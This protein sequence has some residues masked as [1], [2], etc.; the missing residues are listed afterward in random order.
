[1]EP[2]KKMDGLIR[3]P[4]EKGENQQRKEMVIPEPTKME[5]TN[6]MDGN[7]IPEPTK[8]EPTKKMDGNFRTIFTLWGLL[9]ATKENGW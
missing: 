8:I 3:G 4:T 1:M 5:P 7:S 9:L 6:K 2:T